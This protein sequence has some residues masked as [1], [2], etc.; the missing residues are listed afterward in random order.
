MHEVGVAYEILKVA[1]STAKESGAESIKKIGVTVG[2]LSGVEVTS[3]EFAL[4][5]LKEETIAKD[6]V[7]EIEKVTAKGVCCECGKE[8]TPDTFFAVCS[9]CNS[10]ALEITA[11]EDFFISYIDV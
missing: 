6:A 4:N 3:L 10:P 8:S 1:V 5:S 7:I 11:G 2:S 9:Y